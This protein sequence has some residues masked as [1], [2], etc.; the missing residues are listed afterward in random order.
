MSVRD[1]RFIKVAFLSDNP[2]H[3]QTRRALNVHCTQTTAPPLRH[4]K[5]IRKTYLSLSCRRVKEMTYKGGFTKGKEAVRK[6]YRSDLTDE[7]VE[8]GQGSHLPRRQV[9]RPPSEG[10]TFARL[11]TPSSTKLEPGARWDYLPHD[12]LPKS[13][14]LGLLVVASA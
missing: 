11:S 13:T 7:R 4:S 3:W 5:A 9:N 6:S 14:R 1:I 2:L 8:P 12:L 10:W